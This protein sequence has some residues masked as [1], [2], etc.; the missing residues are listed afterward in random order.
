MKAAAPAAAEYSR[1]SPGA[2][3]EV[4]APMPTAYFTSPALTSDWAT[5]ML[6]VPA[7]QAN[8]KSA[9][10]MSGVA[11]MAS[12]TIVPD[13]LTAYGCDSEPM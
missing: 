9:M 12:A 1:A 10:W 6:S 4:S 3:C 7:L 13:G 8:S 5:N 11:P 2:P